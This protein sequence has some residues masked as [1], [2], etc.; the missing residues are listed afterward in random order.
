MV[1]F[2]Y[3]ILSFLT[4]LS[5]DMLKRTFSNFYV[6]SSFT[7]VEYTLFALFLYL[8]FKEKVF[9]YILLGCSLIFYGMAFYTL[10]SQRTADF[11]S[12]S[13]SLEAIFIIIYSILFLYEQ[14]KDPAVFYVFYSK[15]F[16]IIVAFFIYFS[17]TLFLFIYAATFTNQ[18]HK[19]YWGI[20]FIFNILKNIFFSISFAM[21]KTQK[22]PYPIESLYPD[23]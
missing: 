3:C 22:N 15:N 8:C 20:N 16:W 14:I 6:Y 2:F 13:A 17:S 18:Q 21:K 10:F 9:K 5:Y 4:D 12:L 11:D 19:I 1:I 7:I 23:T